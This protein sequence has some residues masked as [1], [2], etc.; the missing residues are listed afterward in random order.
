MSTLLLRLKKFITKTYQLFLEHK[1]PQN[2]I[3]QTHNVTSLFS[4]HSHYSSNHLYTTGTIGNYDPVEQYSIFTSYHDPTRPLFVPQDAL[5]L[6]DEFILPTHVPEALNLNDGFLLPTHVPTSV[7]N[8][9]LNKLVE[10][11][12]DDHCRSLYT[13]LVHKHYSNEQLDFIIAKVSSF[14]L[15]I[16][17]QVLPSQNA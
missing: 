13:S 7:A 9:K 6:N 4:Y 5:N 10:T 16:T 15:K 2:F 11:P 12:L 17:K 14:I 8:S 1:H 3:F